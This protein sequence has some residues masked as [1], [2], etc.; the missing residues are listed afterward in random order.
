M[1]PYTA[2]A[3]VV[4]AARLLGAAHGGGRQRGEGERTQQ[5]GGRRRQRRCDGGKLQPERASRR[6]AAEWVEEQG[7]GVE[8]QR[9]IF[10]D[11][12]NEASVDVFAFELW[13]DPFVKATAVTA[14]KIT[15]FHDGERCADVS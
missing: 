6:R 8:G 3:E 14:L 5:R 10:V 11:K 13:E 2:D 12:A 4:L 15:E 7:V 9:E 1:L